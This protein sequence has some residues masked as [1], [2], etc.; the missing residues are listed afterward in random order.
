MKDFDLLIIGVSVIILGPILIVLS[1]GHL[2]WLIEV[3]KSERADTKWFV[4]LIE[5]TSNN[6]G[7]VGSFLAGIFMTLMG[8][9]LMIAFLVEGILSS[10]R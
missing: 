9:I 2:S 3:I 4:L 10:V 1:W 5:L 7:T 6:L 8:A